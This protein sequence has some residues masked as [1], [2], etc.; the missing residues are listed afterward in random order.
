M[1]AGP[2]AASLTHRRVLRIALPI[3]AAN[4]TVPL[5]GAVDTAV[6]GQLGLAAPIG[7][8]GLGAIILAIFYWMFGFLRMGT[9][10]LTAQAHGA[11]DA[12]E[13]GAILKRGL[14]IAAAAG[15]ALIVLQGPLFWA[16]FRLAPASDEIEGLTQTYLAIRIWGAPAIIASYA[17]TGWL[18]AIERT[19]AVLALQLVMNGLNIGLDLWFVLGLGWGIEG[20]AVATL[21]A[22]WTGL[23]L[24]LWLC[25]AGL[26]ATGARVFDAVRLRRM[27][28]VNGYIMV[29]SIILQGCFTAFLFLSSGRGDLVIAANQVLLQFLE[30]TAYLLDGFAFAAETLVGQ[31]VG[32]RAAGQLGRSVRLTSLWG[33]G[34]AVLMGAVFWL[35]GPAIID[36]MTTAPDV[37]AEAR[38]YLPWVALAPALGI[39]AWMF[40]GI[41]IGATMTREMLLTAT[42]AATVYVVAIFASWGLGNHGLWLSLMIFNVTRG[43]SQ[44]VFYPRIYRTLET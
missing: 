15:L 30:I 22:E 24:G 12:D 20:V 29:R 11:G 41:Y 5:L 36:L 17:I 44:A 38:I 10:G 37:R 34:G 3:V 7:A 2:A 23:G 9:T 43:L 18:I 40:D 21:I 33:A 14:L 27:A 4:V 19:R 25:R 28:S 8:V 39:A 13:S 26:A 6:V 31:A 16:A 42:I 32:A 35:A 1:S